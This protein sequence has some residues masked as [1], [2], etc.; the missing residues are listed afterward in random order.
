[1]IL[2][3]ISFPYYIDTV[4]LEFELTVLQYWNLS[5]ADDSILNVIRYDII[6][7]NV[8]VEAS[9]N[10]SLLAIAWDHKVQVAKLAQ[11][12]LKIDRKLSKRES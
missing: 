4:E 9:G 2:A 6:A 1:M 11:S 3:F 8:P 10:V 12:E 5:N 7:E